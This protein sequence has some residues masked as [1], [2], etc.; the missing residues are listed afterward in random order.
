M[1]RIHFDP[2]IGRFVIQVLVWGIF[3]KTI[4]IAR[5]SE[6]PAKLPSFTFEEH[7]FR[8]YSETIAY[9]QEIGLNTLYKD[10]SKNKY[11]EHMQQDVR[12][13]HSIDTSQFIPDSGR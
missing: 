6:D 4:Q 5:E 1:Y 2:K 9:V 12:F 3:W 10:C 11:R 8:T 13:V 7:S